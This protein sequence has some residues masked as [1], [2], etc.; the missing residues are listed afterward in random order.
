MRLKRFSLSLTL[1][2]ACRH[3]DELKKK[4][5]GKLLKVVE[6]LCEEGLSEVDGITVYYQNNAFYV[7]NPSE[8]EVV[9]VETIK[10]LKEVLKEYGVI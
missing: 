8:D 9:E 7:D 10:E 2:D 5:S 1:R 4:L 3:Y 6:D